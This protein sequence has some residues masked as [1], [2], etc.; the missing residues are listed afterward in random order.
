[1]MDFY[2]FKEIQLYS[3]ALAIFEH[4]NTHDAMIKKFLLL[5]FFLSNYSVKK[6]VSITICPTEPAFQRTSF[7]S[8]T[9]KEVSVESKL[10]LF[11]SAS[12]WHYTMIKRHSQIRMI[13]VELTILRHLHCLPNWP[14]Y[15]WKSRNIKLH[16]FGQNISPWSEAGVQGTIFSVST[17]WIFAS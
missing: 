10:S 15:V 8:F 3:F 16:S 6:E 11:I 9:G 1:M 2:S 5:S 17:S 4:R 14:I 7:S 12:I 13:H